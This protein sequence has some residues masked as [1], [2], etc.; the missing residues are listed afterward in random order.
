MKINEEFI[1][2][3]D[4]TFFDEGYKFADLYLVTGLTK[5]NLF[6]A[7]KH[8][9]KA[10]DEFN[11]AFLNKVSV[12]ANSA[13]CKKGCSTCCCQTV[14][15]TPYELF[16]LADFIEKKFREDALKKII[17]K[18]NNKT[19]STSALKID[20]L[21]RYKETCPLLHPAEG[22]CRAYQA[23]PMACRIYL[24]S[25]VKSCIDDLA[26]PNDDNI[27]PHLYD[28][29]LRIGRMMNEGFHA[30]IRKGKE[31]TLQAFEN[32]IEEGLITALNPESFNNWVNGKKVFRKIE[33]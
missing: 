28:L 31:K 22:F 12:E 6:N 5:E 13:E 8:L 7:Q 2:N 21:L 29:P 1:Q 4:K 20:R 32:T 24:S 30:R 25:S 11:D 26:N 14:L 17:E 23:R 9:Y 27:F 3:L 33:E 15:A 10:I 19:K 16:Y 18:A